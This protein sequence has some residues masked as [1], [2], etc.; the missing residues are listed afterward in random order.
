MNDT[1]SCSEG[2]SGETCDESIVSECAE[3]VC[4]N[5]GTCTL[6][7]TSSV[8]TCP[9][10]YTGLLCQDSSKLLNYYALCDYLQAYIAT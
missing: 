4:E 5:G 8:C 2:F 1:C 10:G 3:N 7:A 6:V 9:D